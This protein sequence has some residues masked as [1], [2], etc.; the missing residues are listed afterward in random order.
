[1]TCL[2]QHDADKSKI[3]KNEVQDSTELNICSL[4]FVAMGNDYLAEHNRSACLWKAKSR[5]K[6]SL[7]SLGN[8]SQRKF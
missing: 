3:L 5:Q 2:R 4:L 8:S 1:M 6:T 7:F